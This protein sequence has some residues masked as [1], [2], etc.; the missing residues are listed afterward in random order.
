MV[1][2]FA[3]HRLTRF[4]IKRDHDNSFLSRLSKQTTQQDLNTPTEKPKKRGKFSFSFGKDSSLHSSFV[5][6]V[7]MTV[8]TTI[9][10]LTITR[11]YD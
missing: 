7:G 2:M 11:T 1:V 10:I 9:E 5:L 8:T 4:F 6:L 3:E